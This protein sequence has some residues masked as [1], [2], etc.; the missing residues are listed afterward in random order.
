MAV[1]T[2]HMVDLW[3]ES[4]RPRVLFRAA[5]SLLDSASAASILWAELIAMAP[6]ILSALPPFSWRGTE[7]GS[8]GRFHWG[9]VTIQKM[10][11]P[12]T[13]IRRPSVFVKTPSGGNEWYEGRFL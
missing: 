7:P 3:P 2:F 11:A 12:N 6:S 5:P 13:R 4:A 8:L 9:L 10:R 1:S